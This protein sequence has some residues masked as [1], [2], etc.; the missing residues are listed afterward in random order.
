MPLS[1]SEIGGGGKSWSPENVGD[2]IAGRIRT[3]ERRPQREFGGG[4]DLTWDDGRPR[5]LTYIEL[6]TDL[7]ESDDDD[8]VR[9]IYAKGGRNF[10]P[11]TG[12]GTSM[13]IAI[14][15]AVKNAGCTS[16]DEGGMLVIQHTGVAKP[17][18]RGYQGAK[19]YR[20]QY[21]APV[22]SVSSDDLFDS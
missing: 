22:Q 13:E 1:L 8:G 19:L 10:E 5:L 4:A 15:E 17:T 3:V 14:A 9:A 20:A 11:A 7:S 18:T 2:K 16:I 6:E 12:T 21:K